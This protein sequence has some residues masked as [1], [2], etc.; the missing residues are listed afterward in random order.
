MAEEEGETELEMCFVRESWP[1]AAGFEDVG[2]QAGT[3]WLPEG[4]QG[5]VLPGASGGRGAADA[6]C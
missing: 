1:T 4:G 5:R 6:E 2:A 3:R